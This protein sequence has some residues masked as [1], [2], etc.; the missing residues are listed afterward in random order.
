MF[1]YT[2]P[3]PDS[4]FDY[5]PQ[6]VDAIWQ[7]QYAM[8][9]TYCRVLMVRLDVRFPQDFPHDGKNTHLS[10]LLNLLSRYYRHHGIGF[11]VVW[12]REQVT[13]GAPHY[14]VVFFIDGSKIQNGVYLQQYAD[15]IW[16]RI[17]GI[18]REN[19]VELGKTE[20]GNHSVMMTRPPAALEGEDR[21]RADYEYWL[22]YSA[23]FQWACYLAKNRDKDLTPHK[24]KTFG[25]SEL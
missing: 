14:H 18:P 5:V 7:R 19:L 11:H 2:V 20:T 6:I 4:R 3:A 1:I 8:L 24:V 25:G 16:Q 10:Y 22:T 9:L 13:S 21:R 15:K 12:A 17:V 23:A